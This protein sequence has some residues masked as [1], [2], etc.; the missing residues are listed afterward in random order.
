MQSRYYGDIEVWNLFVLGL[1]KWKNDAV[2]CR[3]GEIC[4]WL[5]TVRSKTNARVCLFS[6]CVQNWE[7]REHFT[8]SRRWKDSTRDVSTAIWPAVSYRW[9]FAIWRMYLHRPQ[10]TTAMITRPVSVITLYVRIAHWIAWVAVHYEIKVQNRQRVKYM[11]FFQISI[12]VPNF[13]ILQC[14]HNMRVFFPLFHKNQI[15]SI[16]Q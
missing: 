6:P 10:C 13:T 7:I 14:L 12:S 9:S 4:R 8:I 3:S 11:K 16:N 15:N 2:E 5:S 1:Q